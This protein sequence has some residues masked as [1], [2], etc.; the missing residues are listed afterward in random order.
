MV[1]LTIFLGYTNQQGIIQKNDFKR[2][3]ALLNVDSK[4][5]KYISIG[6][7]LSFS[8]EENFAAANSGSLSGGAFSTGGLGRLQFVLPSTLAPFKND[9]SYSLNGAAIGSSPQI[10]GI[11][12]LGYY[13]HSLY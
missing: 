12:N 6:G 2:I 3:S 5:G 11:S 9:G 13:N 8:N 4:V 7:K 1:L 10:V